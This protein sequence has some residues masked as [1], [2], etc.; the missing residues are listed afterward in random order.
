M[1]KDLIP[2]II[3]KGLR[4]L[5]KKAT[6]N[7]AYRPDKVYQSYEDALKSCGQ[8]R[9][10]DSDLVNT[11]VKKNLNFR[12]QLSN[13]VIPVFDMAEVRTLIGLGLVSKTEQLNVIDFG[14]GAGG[15]HYSIAKAALGYKVN[16]KWNVVETPATVSAGK[17]YANEE[18]N[19]FDRIDDAVSDLGRVDLV[20][21]S[22]SLQYTSQPYE[23]LQKLTSI[24]AKSIW[25][26]RTV[27][28]T[29][30][31]DQVIIQKTSLGVSH[32]PGQLPE[33]IVDSVKLIPVTLMQQNE[34]EA[35]LSKNYT[36]RMKIIE[37]RNAFFAD[38]DPIHMYG[39]FCEL[40]NGAT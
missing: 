24:G 1:I 8:G 18:L 14:G 11:V 3:I 29:K 40:K 38:G 10:D 13:A 35:L 16:F 33:G 20:F 2:P 36:I 12:N 9:Y 27:L 25:I 22:C 5:M 30:C 7:N 21:C 23:Y 39:Y 19:F 28:T 32:G 26:T 4:L 31:F 34:V 15:Y 17:K 37:E 6:T